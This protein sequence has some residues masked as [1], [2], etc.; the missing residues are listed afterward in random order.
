[1]GRVPAG[2]NP[3]R[4]TQCLSHSLGDGHVFDCCDSLDFS[5]F[6]VV[7]TFYR[8]STQISQNWIGIINFYVNAFGEWE[9]GSEESIK[10]G[11]TV[12]IPR[13]Q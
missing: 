4:G 7:Q 11:D 10:M 8:T 3:S 13:N 9:T 1:M 2:L 5:E 12:N 6:F